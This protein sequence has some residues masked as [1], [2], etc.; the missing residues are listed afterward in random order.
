MQWVTRPAALI[1]DK[2]GLL[3]VGLLSPSR[4]TLETAHATANAVRPALHQG[5]T[6]TFRTTVTKLS[7]KVSTSASHLQDKGCSKCGKQYVDVT[8]TALQKRFTS[9][10]S[11][12]KHNRT[13][14][15]VA[16][17]FNQDGHSMED[18]TIMVIE[19]ILKDTVSSR[20]KRERYERYWINKL[21]TKTPNGMKLIMHG[22]HKIIELLHISYDNN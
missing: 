2:C 20:S 18:L 15:P 14:K 4:N 9:H 16:A 3:I 11:D 22:F 8:K 17:H 12:I 5:Y 19:K 13:R 7:Y 1:S 6:D 21:K 10:R